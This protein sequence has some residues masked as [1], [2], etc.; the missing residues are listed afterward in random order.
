MHA[1]GKNSL[2]SDR[3]GL[4]D[5]T[6]CVVEAVEC[7]RTGASASPLFLAT[8]RLH[9]IQTVQMNWIYRLGRYLMEPAC[10]TQ[11]SHT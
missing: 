1:R 7:V 5:A 10:F 3:A 2:S 11:V 6:E 9:L 4:R 8:D